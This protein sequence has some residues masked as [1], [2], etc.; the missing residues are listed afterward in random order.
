MVLKEKPEVYH[1]KQTL[2]IHLS[3]EQQHSR[4]ACQ[5]TL[6]AL[7]GV[8]GSYICTQIASVFS[9]YS[10]R[11]HGACTHPSLDPHLILCND[12]AQ[13]DSFMPLIV[14]YW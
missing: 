14:I 1:I 11:G 9:H 5:I 10:A 2:L 13:G 7:C 4:R 6:P 3:V 12:S 8:S